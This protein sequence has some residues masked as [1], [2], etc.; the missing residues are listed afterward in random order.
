ML[1]K[2]LL[3]EFK[4]SNS[5]LF[6]SEIKKELY[7]DYVGS[8]FSMVGSSK[9]NSEP[10]SLPTNLDISILI[11]HPAKREGSGFGSTSDG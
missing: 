6:L 7:S 1:F 10:A 3:T 8:D 5:I 9:H 2:Y 11:K 4:Q